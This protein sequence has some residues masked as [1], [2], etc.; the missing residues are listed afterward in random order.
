MDLP[1]GTD[2]DV[3]AAAGLRIVPGNGRLQLKR[4]QNVG[5][6]VPPRPTAARLGR[7]VPD[8]ARAT[9]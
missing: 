9:R 2:M 7:R 1:R 5:F 8:L 3:D 4:G 6:V